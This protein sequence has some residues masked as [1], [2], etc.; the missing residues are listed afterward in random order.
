[1]DLTWHF[2]SSSLELV[3]LISQTWTIWMPM[4]FLFTQQG[5]KSRCLLI[6]SSL[7]LSGTFNTI[8]CNLPRK[9]LKKYQDSCSTTS[10]GKEY[11][12]TQQLRHRG[13]HSNRNYRT[14]GAW[15]DKCLLTN[16]TSSQRERRDS[17]WRCSKRDMISSRCRTG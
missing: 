17:F 4:K 13:E 7:F 3:V 5:I 12:Q 14:L 2:L 1:M 11:R 6:S 9:L 16:K 10:E 8:Q 15:V